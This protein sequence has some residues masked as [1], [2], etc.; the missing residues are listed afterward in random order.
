MTR[1]LLVLAALATIATSVAGAQGTFPSTIALPNGFQPEGVA[2]AGQQFYVGSI[3]T[4]AVYRGR[5]RTG[6]ARILVRLRRTGCDRLKVDRGGS[7]SPVSSHGNGCLRREKRGALVRTYALSTGGSFINDVVVT[8][9]AAWFTDSQKP[10]LYRVP[11]GPAGRPG[12][13]PPSARSADRRLRARERLQREWHRRETNGKTL[14]IVQSSTGSSY[15]ERDGRNT[16]GHAD[17]ACRARASPTATGSCRTG[18]RCTS[19]EPPERH[20]EDRPLVEADER[21]RRDSHLEPGV[22]RADDDRRARE[23]A[24]RR[25]A[26]FGTPSPAS[27]TYSLT[28]V[29]K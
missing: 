3:P 4:G 12:A 22:R 11:L 20:R 27:A 14:V 10:V 9:K 1:L 29:A 5:M 7:S 6:R 16:R 18:R 8:K 28:Q 26:R 24:L 19:A 13:A 2:I 17:G 23:Q 25:H 21:T 15:R